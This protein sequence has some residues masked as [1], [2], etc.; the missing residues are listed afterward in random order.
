MHL[1]VS[2]YRL[3]C[4]VGLSFVVAVSACDKESADSK[5]KLE[6]T[7]KKYKSEA[8]EMVESSKPED[9]ATYAKELQDA[10]TSIVDKRLKISCKNHLIK[11]EVAQD[12]AKG[13]LFDGGDKNAQVAAAVCNGGIKALRKDVAKAEKEGSL[14]VPWAAS[15][16]DYFARI[17]KDCL[18]KIATGT[19]AE[20]CQ[21]TMQML[22]MS[23]SQKDDGAMSCGMGAAYFPK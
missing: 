7:T 21:N 14:S 8:K 19:Q 20:H 12:Q 15:C 13:K 2:L 10:C 5:S 3:C 18:T 4:L 22:E 9:C 11:F 1:N 17:R 16:K 6:S 23:V